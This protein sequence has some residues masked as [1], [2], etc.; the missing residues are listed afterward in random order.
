V[1]GDPDEEVDGLDLSYLSDKRDL[2]A[3][4]A[5][6]LIGFG[7]STVAGWAEADPPLPH[8]ARDGRPNKLFSERDVA[9]YALSLAPH[10]TRVRSRLIEV[11]A[12][13]RAITVATE[14]DVPADSPVGGPNPVSTDDDPS[15]GAVRPKSARPEAGEASTTSDQSEVSRLT[16]EVIRLEEVVAR[17]QNL[18]QEKHESTHRQEAE[19]LALLRMH[20]S[21]LTAEQ[22]DGIATVRPETDDK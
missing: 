19:W 2:M 8:D 22:L 9:K 10:R 18:L 4:A 14:G 20:S 7:R 13:R 12:S 1:A 15:Q 21:P 16:A 5:A 3:Q 11:I 6:T 17:L